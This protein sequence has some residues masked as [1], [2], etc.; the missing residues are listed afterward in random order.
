MPRLRI[1]ICNHNR[2]VPMKRYKRHSNETG[3][4]IEY[5]DFEWRSDTSRDT[6][7]G[8]AYADVHA[9]KRSE[10]WSCVFHPVHVHASWLSSRKFRRIRNNKVFSLMQIYQNVLLEDFI[11]PNEQKKEFHVL[12]LHV[13]CYRNDI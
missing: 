13:K 10:S 9:S 5:S 1:S 11:F 8:Y 12:M 2:G 7:R 4:K 6:I 3:W